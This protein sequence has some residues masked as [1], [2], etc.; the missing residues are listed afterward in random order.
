MFYARYSWIAVYGS[1]PSLVGP[2]VIGIRYCYRSLRTTACHE[3]VVAGRMGVF[4]MRPTNSVQEEGTASAM[5]SWDVGQEHV[6]RDYALLEAPGTRF[7][8]WRYAKS[9]CV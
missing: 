8:P 1:G 4:C 5:E 3:N 6:E 2:A 7:R 9:S